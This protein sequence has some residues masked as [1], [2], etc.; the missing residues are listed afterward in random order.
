MTVFHTTPP[1]WFESVQDLRPGG[2]RRLGDGFLASFNGKAYH[3]YDFREK[4][5]EVYE[6][7]L[8]LAQKLAIRAELAAA[9]DAA[10]QSNVPPGPAMEHPQDWPAEARAWV[11]MAGLDNQ[12]VGLINAYWNP[13]MR[14]VVVPYETY[15]GHSSWVARR[16]AD[17]HGPKYLGPIGGARGGGALYSWDEGLRAKTLV[18]TE[19]ILSAYRVYRDGAVDALAIM[20]TSL[21]RDVIVQITKDYRRVALWLDPDRWGRMGSGILRGAFEQ[22]DFPVVRVDSERDPKNHAPDYVREKLRWL[23]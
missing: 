5:S 6:P 22:L 20:G 23:I 21:D 3:R 14:R 17:A 9:Q 11:H 1:P 8:T 16:I 15:Q 2:K 10:I 4:T 13:D 19:D 12:D 18:V 7:Q